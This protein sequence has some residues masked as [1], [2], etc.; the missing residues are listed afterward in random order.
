[1]TM[2]ERLLKFDTPLA[3][4][5]IALPHRLSWHLNNFLTNGTKNYLPVHQ[6]HSFLQS[7]LMK[8]AKPS[9]STGI[10]VDTA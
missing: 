6:T 9:P 5:I 3:A 8:P 10:P 1:M 7:V 2:T 4:K